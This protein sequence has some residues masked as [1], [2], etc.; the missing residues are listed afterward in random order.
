MNDRRKQAFSTWHGRVHREGDDAAAGWLVSLFEDDD[1]S[2]DRSLTHGFHA[3]A[4][5]MPPFVARRAVEK[6][7][8]PG[9]LVLDPFA[10]GGT[11]VVEAM[12]RGCAAIGRDLSPL[13]RR[14]ARVRTMITDEATRT[15]LVDTAA[16][17]A[18]ISAERAIE[19]MKPPMPMWSREALEFFP[20]HIALELFGLRAE[21][22]RVP[23]EDPI[24]LPLRMTFSAILSKVVE[25]K[26][27]EGEEPSDRHVARGF[28]SKW[29]GDKA[30]ELARGLAELASVVPEGTP[31]ARIETGDARLLDRIDDA[32]IDAIV[33][34]P[35]YAGV[36]DYAEA[37][38][39]RFVMLRLHREDFQRKQMGARG[40]GSG[41]HPMDWERDR[42]AY[43]QAMARVLKPGACAF[44]IVGDG[45]VGGA[46]ENALTGILNAIKSTPLTR[47]AM[48]SQDRP[49]ADPYLIDLFH[50]LPRREHLIL[51][52]RL[53]N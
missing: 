48:A 36:Y 27:E 44:L 12:R 1:G 5:R 7:A 38:A 19:R 35:P 50:G 51:L 52:R 43:L 42:I 26:P 18:A 10:G 32:S 30:A 28:P 29:F 31:P 9:Q 47:V 2:L 3:Y 25:R 8:R 45:V 16:A 6:L 37:H 15:R 17:I 11:V 34:S 46:P 39:A 21:I 33:T 23:D 24:S 22:G 4:G 13:A 49:P 20:P 41:P 40:D 14:I 53:P